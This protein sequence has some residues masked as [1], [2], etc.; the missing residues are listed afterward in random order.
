LWIL[1]QFGH[2][3]EV[4][5]GRSWFNSGLKRFAGDMDASTDLPQVIAVL[6]TIE[7]GSNGWRS[8]RRLELARFAGP[9][10]LEDWKEQGFPLD[11]E[12]ASVLFDATESS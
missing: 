10:E 3:D 5:V 12:G 7:V 1:D 6:E 11:L 2:F 9:K 8:L 4:D